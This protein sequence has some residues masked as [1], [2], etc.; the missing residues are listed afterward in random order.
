MPHF[1]N[2][3]A[4]LHYLNHPLLSGLGALCVLSMG[5]FILSKNRKSKVYIVFFWMTLV[6]SL[7]F[8]GN[9]L[10]MFYFNNFELA[11]FWF[12][13]GYT[14]VPFISVAYYHFY[15]VQFRDKKKV[16]YL[17]YTICILEVLYLWF[18]N[19]IKTGAY[20]LPNVGVIWR[21]MP[22]FSYFLLFSMV[23][24]IAITGVTAISFLKEYKKENMFLKK[25]QLKFLTIVFSIAI[26]GGIEWLVSFDI[27]IHIGWLVIPLFVGSIAHAII[28]YRLMDIKIVFSRTL[29]IALMLGGLVIFHTLF[30]YL[31]CLIIG[32]SL[33]GYY[34]ASIFSFIIIGYLVFG[35]PLRKKV[36][37]WTNGIILKG[38][39]DYQEILKEAA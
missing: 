28:R 11:L 23:K 29:A 38:K 18:L 9:A 34:P 10:S 22:P 6:I 2:L 4:N 14:G 31:F 39:Y 1:K 5:I 7:W 32:C 25:K 15:L 8:F 37:F 21:G 30:M 27:P 13:F 26:M 36:H 16:L 19:D 24:Y 20:V 35:T 12:K 3:L 33:I 17:L